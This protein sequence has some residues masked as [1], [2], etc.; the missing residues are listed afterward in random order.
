M[1]FI[2]CNLFWFKFSFSY[3]LK[4]SLPQ[5]I[6]FPL[7]FLERI[8]GKEEKGRAREREKFWCEWD[9]LIGCLRLT[10]PYESWGSNLIL[11]KK[12]LLSFGHDLNGI[13]FCSFTVNLCVS[14][15]IKWVSYRHHI[16]NHIFNL[17]FQYV[18]F[19]WGV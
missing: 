18:Y 1:S 10:W 2:S 4:K 12:S 8:E 14:F 9:T 7:I 19:D 16:M 3:F 11:V 15:H 17:F 13:F 6:F 5:D